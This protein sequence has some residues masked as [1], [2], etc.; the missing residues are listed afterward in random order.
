MWMNMVVAGWVKME[1]CRADCGDAIRCLK[2]IFTTR[3]YGLVNC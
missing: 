2:L 1:M 3:I